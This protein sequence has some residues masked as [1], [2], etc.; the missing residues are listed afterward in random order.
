MHYA[1]KIKL[2]IGYCTQFPHRYEG[3]KLWDS[4]II[5]ARFI[6]MHSQ[7][8][9]DKSVIELASGTG[10]AGIA[11]RKW[12]SA[13]VITLTDMSDEVVTNIRNNAKKNG[14]EKQL[15]FRMDW[16]EYDSFKKKYDFI[17]V[18]DPFFHH[19]T[20]ETLYAI[21]FSFLPVGGTLLMA[22]PPSPAVEAFL[23]IV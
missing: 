10:L 23:R 4:N 13:S 5:L 7:I 22:T 9:K 16:K 11:L 19:C 8:F 14:L 21:M 20:P 18:S 15:A 17:I 12:S 2:S 6:V 3:L 1:Y